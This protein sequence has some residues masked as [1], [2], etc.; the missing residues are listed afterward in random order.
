VLAVY[1]AGTLVEQSTLRSST[2]RRMY[3]RGTD[4]K[5][6]RELLQRGLGAPFRKQKAKS[7][8]HVL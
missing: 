8:E 4:P 5:L 1:F 6:D 3:L 7:D 2:D